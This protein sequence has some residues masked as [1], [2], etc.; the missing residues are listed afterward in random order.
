MGSAEKVPI[1]AYR[2][3]KVGWPAAAANKQAPQRRCESLNVL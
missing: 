1:G 3:L 2:E